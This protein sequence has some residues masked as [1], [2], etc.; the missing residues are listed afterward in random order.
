[1]GGGKKPKTPTI[2]ADNLYSQDIVELAFGICE[3][4]IYGL[5]D[6]LKSFYINDLP[7]VSETGEYNFQDV[8]VNLRQGYLDDQ[9]I[10]YLAGGESSVINSTIGLSL[11]A[12]IPRTIVTPAEYRGAIK[13]LDVRVLVRQ[14]FAGNGTDTYESSVIFQVKYRKV[15]DTEWRYVNETTETL[16]DYKRKV[17]TLRQSANAQGLDFDSM[18]P[19]QQYEFELKTLTELKN[20]VSEDLDNVNLPVALDKFTLNGKN[21]W[22]RFLKLSFSVD[23][24]NQYLGDLPAGTTTPQI[25]NEMIVLSGKTTA[26]YVY[27]L[28]IPIFDPSDANHD[29]EVQVVRRSKEL[30]SDEKKYSGKT[31][32]LESIAVVTDT[33]KTYPKTA[34]CHVVAQHTDRFDQVPDFSAEIKGLMCDI[35]VNYNPFTKTWAGFWNGQFKKGWTDNNALIARELIMNRDWGKRASE[36]QLQ[37]DNS[38]LIE[39]INYCDGLV[40]DL[41]S[42]MKPR[43]TFNEVVSA[44]RDIDEYLK[45]VLGSFHATSREIFGVYCFFIDK[46]K[47]AS[48]FISP[49]TVFQTGLAYYRSDL[50]SRYNMIRVSFSNKEN[51]YQEDRRVLLDEDSQ[52]VNGILPYSFTSVGATNL[53]EAIRQA[54]YLMY[55]NKEETTFLTFSQPRLGHVVSLYDNFYVFDKD[56]DWGLGTRISSYDPQTKTIT[57]RDALVQLTDIVGYVVY[58]HSQDGVVQVNAETINPHQLVLGATTATNEELE[59]YLTSIENAPIGLGGGVYG[60]P[61]KFRILSME[62]SDSADVAQGELFTFKSVIVAPLKYEAIDNIDNPTLVNFKYNSLD[63]TYKRDRMPSV[64]TNVTVW[65]RE[66]Y[67]DVDQLAYGLSFNIVDPAYMYK[68]MWVNKETG[69]ARETVLYDTE[70]VLAPAF[71]EGTNLKLKITPYTQKGD[72]GESLIMDNV[73]LGQAQSNGLPKF[74]SAE[75]YEPTKSIRFAFTQ[76]NFNPYTG[77]NYVEAYANS[78]SPTTTRG[79][80]KIDTTSTFYDVPYVGSGSYKLSLRFEATTAANQGFSDTQITETWYYYGDQGSSLPI[81]KFPAPTVLSIDSYT[82][83]KKQWNAYDASAGKVFVHLVLQIPDYADYPN[84]EQNFRDHTFYSPFL[85]VCSDNADLNYRIMGYYVY[86]LK[87]TD[88]NAQG[89]FDMYLEL[90]IG[91]N[92]IPDET[93]VGAKL[94]IKVIENNTGFIPVAPDYIFNQLDSTWTEVTV[95][96]LGTN[97][98]DPTNVYNS[99]ST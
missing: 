52:A 27:E 98:F 96:A 93:N 18:T 33:N 32:T 38:S 39:A 10:P 44:E 79:G 25:Q 61:K 81:N 87:R 97:G 43:H 60:Y 14:L 66:L 90:Q 68:V 42:V 55:T 47:E 35:P 28:S 92:N 77:L 53:S 21:F 8:A 88:T 20:I 56:L 24:Y 69:E 37:V 41:N 64:P 83:T 75:Y 72:A 2:T 17:A 82:R 3:G 70:G 85:I 50:S 19:E 73:V 76:A 58:I 1:M 94:K 59:Y 36:P 6:G 23:R 57:L 9:P 13:F 4:T 31:I 29:W 65:L 30:T 95:P 71:P 11:P 45:Y 99:N 62:Q 63:L 49:E 5:N 86:P 80:V 46:P 78:D 84:F 89:V 22:S 16:N 12:D 74:I 67:N 34:M 54:V 7:L 48:F 40:P 26:G 91:I 51:N 15:G